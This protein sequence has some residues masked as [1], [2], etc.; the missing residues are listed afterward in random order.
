MRQQGQSQPKPQTQWIHDITSKI[1]QWKEEGEVILLVDA[2]SGLED[3]D[4]ALFIAKTGVCDIIGATHG[5]DTP[6]TQ[7]NGSKTI[8]FLLCTPNTMVTI[9][10]CG[11]FRFYKGIHS[12]HQGLFCDMNILH[13]LRGE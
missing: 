10:K 12:D 11:V 8:D 6:N 4:F 2:N 9:K 7:A 5:I 1:K 3:K 13:L